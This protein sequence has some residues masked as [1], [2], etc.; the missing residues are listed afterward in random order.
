M[1]ELIQPP[2]SA[3]VDR[4]LAMRREI[5]DISRRIEQLLANYGTGRA[6]NAVYLLEIVLVLKKSQ[7]T[8]MTRARTGDSAA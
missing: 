6:V 3:A 8:A 7:L 5:R 2:A 4:S 1:R